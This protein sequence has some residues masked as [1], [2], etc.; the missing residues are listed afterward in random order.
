MSSITE[1]DAELFMFY[2]LSSNDGGDVKVKFWLHAD[3]EDGKAIPL[4]HKICEHY[5]T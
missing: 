3:S 5:G 1:L 4:K 2:H